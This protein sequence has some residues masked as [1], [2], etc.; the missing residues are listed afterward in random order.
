MKQLFVIFFILNILIHAQETNT[1]VTD[2]SSGKP[3]LVGYV[4][5]DA[6]KDTSFS[7]WF[8]SEYNNY[9]TDTA[10]AKLFAEKVSDF[11][12]TIVM[13]SWCSDSRREVPRFLRIL[14]VLNFNSSAGLKII[15]VGRDKKRIGNEAQG[16]NIE[17]VPT[18]II[19][20]KGVEIGRIIESPKLTLEKDLLTLTLKEQ[21]K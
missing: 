7:W 8:D 1:I 18:F 2:T 4:T 6:F 15:C 5:R 16:L 14:D 21:G 12:V 17:L 10:S 20:Q 13:G 11:T 19:S 3:M 9:E